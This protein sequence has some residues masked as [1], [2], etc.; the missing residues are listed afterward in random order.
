MSV[1]VH[2]TLYAE[3]YTIR[4]PGMYV[5]MYQTISHCALR[6]LL[7]DVQV[8]ALSPSHWSVARMEVDNDNEVD[9]E[10]DNDNICVR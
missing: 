8:C 9:N 6:F 7:P 3:V 1:S 5:F 4:C 10:V 2:I